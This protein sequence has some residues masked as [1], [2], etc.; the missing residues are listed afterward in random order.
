MPQDRV[1]H[2]VQCAVR[3]GQVFHGD[4]LLAVDHAQKADA[5]VDRRVLKPAA[6]QGAERHSAGAAVTLGAALLAAAGMAAQPQIVEEGLVRGHIGERDDLA[7]VEK[8][9]RRAGVMRQLPR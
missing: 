9:N 4:Q 2:G 8:P 3:A 6:L 5:A 1:L 7:A